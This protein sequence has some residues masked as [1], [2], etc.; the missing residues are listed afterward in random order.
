MSGNGASMLGCGPLTL[1]I[2]HLC[3][4]F[5]LHGCLDDNPPPSPRA[6]SRTSAVTP[7]E[8]GRLNREPRG[9]DAKFAQS[10]RRREIKDEESG[11]AAS[12][13]GT[14]H[15]TSAFVA[16]AW[17]QLRPAA[18]TARAPLAAQRLHVASISMRG[19]CCGFFFL[20]FFD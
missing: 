6:Q 16:P 1:S 19:S 20:F 18:R 17:A 14:K 12:C 8:G 7:P 4:V 15:H 11:E 10:K 2:V 13:Q 3:V 9:R 5:C